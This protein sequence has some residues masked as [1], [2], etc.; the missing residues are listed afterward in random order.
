MTVDRARLMEILD[1]AL[2][3]APGERGAVL[4]ERCGG[5]SA[6]R[7]EVEKLLSL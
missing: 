5:D 4:A 2:E 1:A 3:A 7:C 6:L